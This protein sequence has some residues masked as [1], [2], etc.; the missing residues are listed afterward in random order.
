MSFICILVFIP[1]IQASIY[2]R[3][4]AAWNKRVGLT[5]DGKI[6][7]GCKAFSGRCR[8]EIWGIIFIHVPYMNE[9][10]YVCMYPDCSDQVRSSFQGGTAEVSQVRLHSNIIEARSVLFALCARGEFRGQHRHGRSEARHHSGALADVGKWRIVVDFT[11]I[12]RSYFIKSSR[13]FPFCFLFC[14]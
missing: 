7:R 8:N 14:L 4:F 5:Y 6:K 3:G 2:S 10:M 9:C 1:I 12:C 11:C 13:R